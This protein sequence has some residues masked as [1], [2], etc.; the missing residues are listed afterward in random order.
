MGPLGAPENSRLAGK[1]GKEGAPDI[2][3]RLQEELRKEARAQQGWRLEASA[4]AGPGGTLQGPSSGLSLCFQAGPRVNISCCP[5]AQ[6]TFSQMNQS[7][8]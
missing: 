8:A 3:R 1:S 5:W 2:A 4:G 6:P 7:E